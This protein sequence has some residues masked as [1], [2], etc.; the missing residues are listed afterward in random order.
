MNSRSAIEKRPMANP[1]TMVRHPGPHPR[2]KRAFIRQV[3]ARA[4]G[5]EIVRHVMA[6]R[7]A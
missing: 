4:I 5:V 6:L 3:I 2:Q 1:N 7:D